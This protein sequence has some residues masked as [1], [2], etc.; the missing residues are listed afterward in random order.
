MGSKYVITK[1]DF[2]GGWAV[3]SPLETVDYGAG[4][5]TSSRGT[6]VDSHPEALAWMDTDALEQFE[7][8]F[9]THTAVEPAV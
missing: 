4:A 3:V 1:S 5:V 6:T 9:Y 2:L 8:F 7:R